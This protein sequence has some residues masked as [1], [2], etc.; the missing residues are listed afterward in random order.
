MKVPRPGIEP[1]PLLYMTAKLLIQQ[2]Q[3]HSVLFMGMISFNPH[4]QEVGSILYLSDAELRLGEVRELTQG[5][6]GFQ[7]PTQASAVGSLTHCTT[8]KTPG[9]GL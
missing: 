3:Q 9:P 7:A 8:V 2:E 6:L 1:T 4:P 5:P